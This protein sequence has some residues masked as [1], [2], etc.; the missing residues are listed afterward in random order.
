[1]LTLHTD[2]PARSIDSRDVQGA[3]LT[4]GV[5]FSSLTIN[6]VVDVAH[7]LNTLLPDFFSLVEAY[8]RPTLEG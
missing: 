7:A 1:M 2:I 5:L 6:Q 8:Y 4:L 3:A